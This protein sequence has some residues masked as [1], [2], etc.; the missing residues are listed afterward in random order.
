MDVEDKKCVAEII[1][2]ILDEAGVKETD[3]AKYVPPV[4]PTAAEIVL[5]GEAP[6]SEEISRKPPRPFVGSAGHYLDMILEMTGLY[7]GELYITNLR[8]TP[9]PHYK[10]SNVPY[11]EILEHRKELTEELNTLENPKIII[12]LGKYALEAVTGRS[13]I[14]N[15]R[16][17]V[18]RPRPEIKQDV[19]VIPTFHPSIMHYNYTSWPYIVADLTRAKK[20]KEKNYEFE[21]PQFEFI[22]RPNFEKVMNTL[23]MLEKDFPAPA[24][25]DSLKNLVVIDVENPHKLLSCIGLAW[26]KKHAISIPFYW[27]SGHNYWSY[28][29]ELAIWKKLGQVLPKLNLAAQNAMYDWEVMRNHKIILR[30]AFWDSM[31][32]H[33][34]LYSEMSHK[35]DAITSI[36]TDMEFYKRT[37]DEDEKRSAIKAGKEKDHWEYNM[38]DCVSC[39]WAILELAKELEEEG[40][41]PVYK[42][43]FGEMLNPLYEMNMRGV[44]VDVKRLP[45]VRKELNAGIE[46]KMQRVT[47]AVGYEINPN[48][49]PQVRKALTEAL[50]MELPRDKDGAVST[51]KK[52]LEKLAYKYRSDVPTLILELREDRSFLTAFNEDSIADGRFRTQ[53]TLSVTKTGR[54]SARKPVS[55][56]GRNL[57]NV[58]RGPARSFFIAEPGDILVGGDQMQAEA[59][60]VAYYSQDENYITAAESGRIHLNV[61][62]AVFGEGFTKESKEY[63]ITKRLVHGTDYGLGPWGFAYQ[64]NIPFTEAKQKQQDF[65]NAYPGIKGVYYAYVEDCIRRTRMLHNVFGRR[66]IFLDRI[67][68]ST[69]RKGYA[70]IPQSSVT[71][72]TKKALKKLFKYYVVLLD[73]HD[74]IIMSVPRKEVKYGIEAMYEAFDVPF[75][76]WGIERKIPIEVMVGENWDA[77]EKVQT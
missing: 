2:L 20:L 57:Q 8:K 14:T 27:G 12:P 39:F 59:R 28:E 66:Q 35:L 46:A 25:A 26:S 56:K 19:L 76:I 67:N 63:N 52:A 32:M 54:L 48:S 15:L 53:Y 40:M 68:E 16:G 9:A 29:Q 21:T 36:F 30:P 41:M 65:Y 62:E 74:G 47:D 34:C 13:G 61:M 37:E 45:S 31:L 60:I 5:I 10:M 50:K 44:P 3:M 22:T 43:F 64:A 77:M 75:K 7:R 6:A 1:R 71:D 72:I 11:A 70:F 23:T 24:E 38:K 58:K 73:L 18:L 49:Y 17:S 33:A 42:E 4:G 55:K 51:N 69:F